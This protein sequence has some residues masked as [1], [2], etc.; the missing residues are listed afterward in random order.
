MI[1][2]L[3]RRLKAATAQVPTVA[4]CAL[5]PLRR[6]SLDW[7][8]GW[9]YDSGMAGEITQ[10]LEAIQAGDATPSE[11]ISLVYQELRQLALR[12]ISGERS[13][14]TLQATALVHEAYLRLLGDGAQTWENR[15]H[16]FAAAAEAMRRILIEN[17]R[18]KSALKRGGGLSRHALDERTAAEPAADSD[19]LLVDE[20]LNQLA[21]VDEQAAALVK[22]RYFGGLTI[23]EIAQVLDM[24]PRSADRLWA[25]AKA[26]L[27]KQIC[28]D[29]GRDLA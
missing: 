14:H 2:S 21:G 9:P 6:S 19:L 12:Q 29:E 13:G 20:A 10:I 3:Y 26:W 11:L 4:H 16:F 25:F 18:Q 27:Y 24:S 23:P 8:D 7:R 22:L 17:A 1:S 15:R 28:Q 5:E